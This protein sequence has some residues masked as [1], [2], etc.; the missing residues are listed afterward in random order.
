MVYTMKIYTDGGCRNNGYTNAK[1]AAAAV[2]KTRHRTLSYTRKL[3]ST[4][5]PS[6]TSQRAEITAIII[7]LEEALRRY[8]NLASDPYL[9]VTIY[10]DSRYAVNCMSEWIY[11]WSNNGWKNSM[12]NPVANQDLLRRASS[13]DDDL[14][15]EGDVEYIWIPRSENFRADELCQEILDESDS[16]SDSDY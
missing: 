1:G 4:E 13:L 11:K 7:A 5:S 14:R 8:R 16:D 15:D 2:F 9:S 10:S 6:P 3:P 12:G